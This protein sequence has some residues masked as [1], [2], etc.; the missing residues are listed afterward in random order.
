MLPETK[1]MAWRSLYPKALASEWEGELTMNTIFQ[2]LSSATMEHLGQ[3]DSE[4]R[5]TL[6]ASWRQ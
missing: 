4:K 1:I 3:K 2:G 6:A 5:L